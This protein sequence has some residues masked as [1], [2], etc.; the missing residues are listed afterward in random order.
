MRPFPLSLLPPRS[1]SS[2]E[3]VFE[4]SASPTL[5]VSTYRR[6]LFSI[7]SRDGFFSRPRA[8]GIRYRVPSA[9]LRLLARRRRR[10][11]KF[12]RALRRN[13]DDDGEEREGTYEIMAGGGRAT[14]SAIG[15]SVVHQVYG[16][17]LH[18]WPARDIEEDESFYVSC[19]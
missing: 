4:T 2:L 19:L 11:L 3:R 15:I 7:D 9:A 17:A 14:S 12:K 6:R 10:V 5:I 13:D 18:A 16:I 1:P 8:I